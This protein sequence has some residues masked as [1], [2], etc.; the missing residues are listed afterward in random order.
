MVDDVS[1]H[2]G[3]RTGLRRPNRGRPQRQRSPSLQ[4]AAAS[5]PLVTDVQDA[6]YHPPHRCQ[7]G[8]EGGEVLASEVSAVG[9][10]RR[11]CRGGVEASDLS[12]VA[13]LMRT[14]LKRSVSLP[15]HTLLDDEVPVDT[16]ERSQYA[17]WAKIAALAPQGPASRCVSLSL[18]IV[19]EVSP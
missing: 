15:D 3:V 11:G 7:A 5:G 8:G 6:Q 18:V 16:D 13:C 14:R 4:E 1:G 9:S 12:A 2:G 10:R 17:D 19:A